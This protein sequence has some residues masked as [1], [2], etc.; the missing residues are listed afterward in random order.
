MRRGEVRWYKFDHPD[1]RRPVLI[2]HRTEVIEF[3]SEITVAPIT[4]RVRDL[5][6]EVFLS[7]DAVK[8]LRESAVNLDH[9][10][11]VPKAK[12]GAV[13]TTLDEGLMRQVDR[14]IRFALGF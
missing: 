3:L 1:K 7:A 10:A 14:A 5:P 8:V 2:L 13:I 4:T 11:T 12:I 6:S 9:I